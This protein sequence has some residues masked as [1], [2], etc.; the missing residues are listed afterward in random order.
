MI[1]NQQV[2]SHDLIWRSKQIIFE[3]E[4]RIVF[5]QRKLQRIINKN[6]FFF[7]KFVANHLLRS[8]KR[9]KTQRTERSLLTDNVRNENNIAFYK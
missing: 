9:R 8:E 2:I 1:D 3:I 5:K 6:V 4:E 7:I